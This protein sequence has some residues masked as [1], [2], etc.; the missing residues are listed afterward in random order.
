MQCPRVD[1]PIHWVSEAEQHTHLERLVDLH[2]DTKSSST[3]GYYK[4]SIGDYPAT[5][6]CYCP[7][8]P[9]AAAFDEDPLVGFVA[10]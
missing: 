5:Q 3:E 1:D 7:T 4:H 9:L 6:C 10:V 8:S 2:T